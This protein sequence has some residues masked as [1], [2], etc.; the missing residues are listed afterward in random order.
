M[1]QHDVMRDAERIA[2]EGKFARFVDAMG[3]RMAAV[4]KLQA[5]ATLRNATTIRVRSWNYG[6]WTPLDDSQPCERN[7]VRAR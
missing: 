3:A 1:I 6:P 2:F 4:L 5:Q 7:R